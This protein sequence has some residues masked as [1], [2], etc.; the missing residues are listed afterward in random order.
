MTLG[1]FKDSLFGKPSRSAWLGRDC[2]IVRRFWLLG[3]VVLDDT[4]MYRTEEG[5]VPGGR[6]PGVEE[7]IV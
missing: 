1:V 2:C 5:S 4:V 3:V 7:D 6:F